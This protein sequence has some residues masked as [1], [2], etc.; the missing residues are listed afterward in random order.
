M[1]SNKDLIQQS[2]GKHSAVDLNGSLLGT[3]NRELRFPVQPHSSHEIP[4]APSSWK[5]NPL[6][7]LK[8]ILYIMVIH[9][10]W[11][12]FNNPQLP[13]VRFSCLSLDV[14]CI[15]HTSWYFNHPIKIKVMQPWLLS[16]LWTFYHYKFFKTLNVCKKKKVFWI[17]P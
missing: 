17:Y 11:G 13:L 15:K 16:S 8:T 7:R 10:H 1:I 5:L 14:F 4:K 9:G 6:L 2:F 12:R 3:R